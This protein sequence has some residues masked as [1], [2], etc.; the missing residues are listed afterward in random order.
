MQKNMTLGVGILGAGTMGTLH[1]EILS[2][3]PRVELVAVTDIQQEARDRFAGRFHV[4]PFRNLESMME[5]GIEIL[6]ITTPNTTHTKPTLEA[7]RNNIHV[8]CEKPFATSLQEAKQIVEAASASQSVYQGGH[9]RRFAPAYR[10]L[11]D[12]IDQGFTPYLATIKMND[13]DLKDPPWLSDRTKTGG[14]LYETTI[15]LLD[16]ALWLMG[17]AIEVTALA[18]D[19]LYPDLVDWAILIGFRNGGM[20]TLTSSGHASW[21]TPTERVEIIG[22]HAILVCEGTDSVSHSPGLGQPVEILSFHQ[23]PRKQRWGYIQENDAFIRAVRGELPS[24]FSVVEGFKIIQLIEA[25]YQ[26]VKTGRTIRLE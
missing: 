7:L 20:A 18:K 3:D 8:F 17:D 11:K 16:T 14:F 4:Q 19:N 9:N 23:L 2:E 15:H 24:A 21:H 10:F 25:C 22:D 13:G 12:R 26:S 6:Y 5:R 1:A